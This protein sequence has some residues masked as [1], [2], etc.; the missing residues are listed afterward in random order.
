MMLVI[1]S[2]LICW[3][4]YTLRVFVEF[5]T[6]ENYFLSNKLGEFYGK[7]GRIAGKALRSIVYHFT[8]LNSVFDPI[9]CYFRMRDVRMAVNGLFFKGKVTDLSIHHG[10]LRTQKSST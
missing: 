7:Q 3:L 6:N 10:S 8:I 9:I 2:F 1:G 4:P 5:V